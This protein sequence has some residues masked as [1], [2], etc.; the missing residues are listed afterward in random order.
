MPTLSTYST[1]PSL[2][3][4]DNKRSRGEEEDP[5]WDDHVSVAFVTNEGMT[6]WIRLIETYDKPI[7]REY[8]I[9]PKSRLIK[10]YGDIEKDG[11]WVREVEG[12]VSYDY[13][14][15]TAG[16]T[17]RGHKE[18]PKETY[19]FKKTNFIDKH[20][21]TVATIHVNVAVDVD[22]D[23][24]NRRRRTN[25]DGSSQVEPGTKGIITSINL[26]WL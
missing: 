23:E 14:I 16:D 9:P 2:T 6:G 24:L 7:G 17:D 18:N 20:S 11:C 15:K 8:K 12:G 26:N 10:L 22:K 19:N 13:Q 3:K 4:L 1:L 25:D 5:Y 21:Q